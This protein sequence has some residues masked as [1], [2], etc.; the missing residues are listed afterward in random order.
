MF[1]WSKT[2]ML[3][4]HWIKEPKMHKATYTKIWNKRLNSRI[5]DQLHNGYGMGALLINFAKR[6]LQSCK[7]YRLTLYPSFIV[8]DFIRYF[9][10]VSTVWIYGHLH[11]TKTVSDLS[12]TVSLYSLRLAFLTGNSSNSQALVTFQRNAFDIFRQLDVWQVQNAV[13]NYWYVIQL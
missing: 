3:F 1:R 2:M 9:S 8:N 10:S 11:Q 13:N 4:E 6:L 5:M 12:G 7:T